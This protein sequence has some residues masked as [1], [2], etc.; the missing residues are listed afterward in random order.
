L[1]FLPLAL[2]TP[3]TT[4][5]VADP[6]NIGMDAMKF[7]QEGRYGDEFLISVIDKNLF[8]IKNHTAKTV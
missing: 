8:H 1:L 2:I 7:V 3:Q 6:S 4:A 5:T